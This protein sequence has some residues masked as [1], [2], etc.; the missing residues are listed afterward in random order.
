M[1]IVSVTGVSIKASVELVAATAFTPLFWVFVAAFY[2]VNALVVPI[3]F[4]G[5]PSLDRLLVFWVVLFFVVFVCYLIILSALVGL[6]QELGW[7]KVYHIIPGG[8]TIA[9]TYSVARAMAYVLDLGWHQGLL[10]NLNTMALRTA[11][12]EFGMVWYSVY[13]YPHVVK[14]MDKNRHTALGGNGHR[15]IDDRAPNSADGTFDIGGTLVRAEGILRIEAADHYL[16]V[17]LNDGHKH[18]VRQ[19]ISD[20]CARIPPQLGCRI[21]RSHW[22]CLGLL[23]TA[24]L[25]SPKPRLTLPDGKT[26]TIARARRQAVRDWQVRMSGQVTPISAGRAAAVLV[27]PTRGPAGNNRSRPRVR[28]QAGASLKSHEPTQA[29]ASPDSA[30]A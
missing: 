15:L 18:M 30:T 8:L 20:L 29:R 28:V 10:Q 1:R 26:I 4:T 27:I 5:T 23:Q 25:C 12:F 11:V 16:F 3:P 2:G 9:L 22:V 6:A 13:I 14:R 24:D 19:N 17:H 7:Q 21:H